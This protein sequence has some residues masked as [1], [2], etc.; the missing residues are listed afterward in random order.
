MSQEV[1]YYNLDQFSIIGRAVYIVGWCRDYKLR[2]F[3]DNQE[4]PIIVHAVERPDVAAVFND[5]SAAQWGFAATALFSLDLMDRALIRLEFAPGLA[6]SDPAQ[7]CVPLEDGPFAEMQGRFLEEVHAKGGSLLE[8]GS[9]ARSGNSYRNWFPDDID[10]VGFDIT[11]GPNVTVVGDAHHMSEV[12]DRK[13]DFMFSISV[14]EHLLM[15]W[16]VA[17]EMSKVLKLGGRAFIASHASY[18]LHDTPWDFWRFSTDAWKGIFNSHTG[19][20]ILDAQYR[21]PAHIVPRLANGVGFEHMSRGPG[22]FT[23]GCV[24]EKTGEAQVEWSRSPAEIYDLQY[25][26][27]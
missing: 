26:H 7:G 12:L 25:S 3:Y 13:F 17:I 18:P 6:F 5:P 4:L 24:I 10:Y 1:L 22:Y 19:F 9:R 11:A 23:S 14:F 20:T 8:I 2:L 27:A 21:F 16:K 15:P